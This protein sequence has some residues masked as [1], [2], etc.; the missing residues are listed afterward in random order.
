[1]HIEK[2]QTRLSWSETTD[3]TTDIKT[4]D[5]RDYRQDSADQV[6]SMKAWGPEFRFLHPHKKPGTM[7]KWQSL[8]V[9]TQMPLWGELLRVTQKLSGEFYGG[10]TW[11]IHMSYAVDES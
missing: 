3:K 11:Y 7:A 1:M 9:T 6:L 10:S 2:L 5:I 4:T 8:N